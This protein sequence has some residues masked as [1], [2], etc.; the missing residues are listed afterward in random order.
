MTSAQIYALG[1]SYLRCAYSGE[2][3]FGQDTARTNS[4]ERDLIIFAILSSTEFEIPSSAV[5]D[6]SCTIAGMMFLANAAIS[7]M[8]NWC[9]ALVPGIK[10]SQ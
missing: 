2:A 7:L 1:G 10:D 4:C 6:K 5:S 9:A 8:S 3:G